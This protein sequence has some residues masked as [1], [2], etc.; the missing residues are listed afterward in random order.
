[1]YIYWLQLKWLEPDLINLQEVERSHF[2]VLADELGQL[3]FQGVHKVHYEKQHGLATFYKTER[4]ELE[5]SVSRHFNK[6]MSKIFKEDQ[7]V[8]KNKH[9]ERIVLFSH[10]SDRRTGRSIV[11]G[12]S[13]FF[14]SNEHWFWT[15]NAEAPRMDTLNE[16][17]FIFS[18]MNERMLAMFYVEASM[19]IGFTYKN[20]HIRGPDSVYS[21]F[22]LKLRQ[23]DLSLQWWGFA[24]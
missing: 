6:L 23:S 9:N 8:D 20:W 15:L 2:S 14:S 16:K 21:S 24:I 1:M 11:V 12:I 18:P 13:L 22:N 7:F 17:T 3:G 4:F 5:K 19:L 10:F